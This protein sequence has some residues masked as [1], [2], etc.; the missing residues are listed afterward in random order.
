[1]QAWFK[2]GL[3]FFRLW[4]S[5]FGASMTLEQ[6]V[7]LLIGEMTIANLDLAERLQ[8]AQARI[9]ELEK[10]AAERKV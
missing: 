1:M 4:H 10:A 2:I 3:R 7:K 9:A 8:V 6:R 5:I